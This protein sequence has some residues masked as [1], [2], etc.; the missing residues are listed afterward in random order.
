MRG[1]LIYCPCCCWRPGVSSRWLC[2]REIG[3][4]GSKWNTFETRGV[5]PQC[6]WHWEI[7]QCLSC[8]QYSAHVHWYHDPKP[9]PAR[10]ERREREVSGVR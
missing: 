5:C 6:S 9:E 3:G 7:T 8:G 10:A 2:S 4:C 1:P